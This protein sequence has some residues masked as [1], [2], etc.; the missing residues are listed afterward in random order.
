VAYQP[1]GVSVP[2]L[3][4]IPLLFDH[5]MTTEVTKA[6]QGKTFMCK[7]PLGQLY[8]E[9]KLDVDTDGSVFAAQ[10]HPRGQM[11]TSAKDANGNDL[12]AD[13]INYFVLPGGFYSQ[14]GIQIGDIGVVIFGTRKVFACFGD[15]GPPNLLGEGSIAL[16][17]ALGHETIRNNR[18]IAAS[19]GG[20]G[21]DA[22]VITIV[23]P[24]SGNGLGRTNAESRQIGEAFFTRL[25]AE[26]AFFGVAQTVVPPVQGMLRSVYR[27]FGG[28]QPTRP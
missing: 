28:S 1:P 26:A 27:A 9:S 23:F 18:L 10:D 5:P 15:V 20:D 19:K 3:G 16:H 8:F 21:I 14:H 24:G 22:G 4:Q 13:Q 6:F 2:I 25:Q 7:F 11:T 12:D 17:R